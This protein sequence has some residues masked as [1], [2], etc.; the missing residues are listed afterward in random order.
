MK[1]GTEL[2]KVEPPVDN[3]FPEFIV[4][5]TRDGVMQIYSTDRADKGFYIVQV[6]MV[7]DN[8]QL[9][10]NANGLF[11][12]S[13]TIDPFNPPAGFIYTTSFTIT[14]EMQDPVAEID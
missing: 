7:L 14:I 6:T 8:L 9:F 3:K 2:A 10:S 12:P 13:V 5:A 1:N 11:S 4:Q